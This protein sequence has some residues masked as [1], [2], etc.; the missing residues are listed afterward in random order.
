MDC[1]GVLTGSE[2]RER[3]HYVTKAQGGYGA[4]REVIELILK[5]QD[6][7]N[8]L[9]KRYVDTSPAVD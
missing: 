4:I 2:T 8:D 1:D 5:A 7:W 9:V 3:A 6:R